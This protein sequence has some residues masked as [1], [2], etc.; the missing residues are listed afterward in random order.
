MNDDVLT[1][2]PAPPVTERGTR[3]EMLVRRD[4][5]SRE[6]REMRAI[7]GE[8]MG[9]LCKQWD[10]PQS[11]FGDYA[12]LCFLIVQCLDGAFTYLGVTFWG[13]GIEANPLI[14]STV[15]AVGLGAGLAAAKLVAA[16][17]G[18][19]LHLRRVHTLVAFLTALYFAVAILPWTAL[20]LAN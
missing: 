4:R 8:R 11:R 20:F 6:V 9:T 18:V 5:L 7:P 13:V 17:F 19:L 1:T 12:V 10:A 2:S 14:V 15:Q 16:S 3:F